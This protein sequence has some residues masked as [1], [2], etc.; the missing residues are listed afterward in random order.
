MKENS[1][2]GKIYSMVRRI[3]RGK[4]ASYGQIAKMVGRCT[5]RMVGY[6][7]AGLPWG[8]DV[9]WQ[10]VINSR[11]EISPRSA[12]DGALRQRKFLES[13]GVRFDFRG[14]VDWEK[15]GWK[16]QG[17]GARDEENESRASR[18]LKTGP[19]DGGAPQGWG[20]K[21]FQ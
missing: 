14:R 2:Y 19:Q 7:M 13:E 17:R 18:N 16:R 1:I 6:A 11:G 10:R 12:G 20:R 21:Q 4:V 8:S 15:V 9:P 5:P 3:P